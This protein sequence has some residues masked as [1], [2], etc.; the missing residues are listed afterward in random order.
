MISIDPDQL[1]LCLQVLSEV[2]SLPPEHPDAVAGPQIVAAHVP[3]GLM[4][5]TPAAWNGAMSRVATAMRWVAAVA[6]M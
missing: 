4:T 5:V 1:R 6:A 3:Q 2:E